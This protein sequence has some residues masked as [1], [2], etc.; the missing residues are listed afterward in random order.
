MHYDICVYTTASLGIAQR[1]LKE[2]WTGASTSLA[3]IRTTEEACLRYFVKANKRGKH[4]FRYLLAKGANLRQLY[5]CRQFFQGTSL[6]ALWLEWRKER[7]GD[8]E[9]QKPTYRKAL[10]DK[11]V[12]NEVRGM[13]RH[14]VDNTPTSLDLF[15]RT[16]FGHHLAYCV[17]DDLQERGLERGDDGRWY[18]PERQCGLPP[19]VENGQALW[20]KR[21]GQSANEIISR[22]VRDLCDK[23]ATWEDK[24]VAYCS[25]QGDDSHNNKHLFTPPQQPPEHFD[26]WFEQSLETIQQQLGVVQRE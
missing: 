22:F 18:F 21:T 20:E 25:G 12:Q 5:G 3:N 24:N 13:I 8:K 1:V 2:A 19:R 4:K 10:R 9:M 7:F 11:D 16:R 23:M 14:I 6:D 17:L 26:D 15:Q